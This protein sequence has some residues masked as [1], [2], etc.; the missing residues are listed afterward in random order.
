MNIKH[1]IFGLLPLQS[2]GRYDKAEAD[3]TKEAFFDEIKDT[4]SKPFFDKVFSYIDQLNENNDFV[5]RA[6]LDFD[7]TI[8]TNAFL[9]TVFEYQVENHRFAFK[10]KDDIDKVFGFSLVDKKKLSCVPTTFKGDMENN[11]QPTGDFSKIVDLIKKSF[12]T[13]SL[14]DGPTTANL[15]YTWNKQAY[16]HMKATKGCEYLHH[17]LQV[18]LLH[19]MGEKARETLMRDALA[20]AK[21]KVDPKFVDVKIDGIKVTTKLYNNNA[22][23]FTEQVKL[24]AALG[25]RGVKTCIISATHYAYLKVAIKIFELTGISEV[26]GS[27]PKDGEEENILRGDGVAIAG[28]GKATLIKEKWNEPSTKLVFS[29]GDSSNDYPMLRHVLE[30][31]GYIVVQSDHA[32]EDATMKQVLERNNK[33]RFQ[34]VNEKQAKWI[35]NLPKGGNENK[36]ASS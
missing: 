35:S 14:K 29:A 19:N 32:V 21:G 6:L 9:T 17:T 12:A 28:E 27:T 33:A 8:A 34:P 26:Y 3:R 23:P 22:I 24:L 5:L 20:A 18:R 2:Y 36:E 25:A 4:G 31:G 13:G 15:I 1:L 11:V 7:G 16:V 30:K 10:S